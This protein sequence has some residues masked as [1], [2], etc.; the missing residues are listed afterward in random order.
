MLVTILSLVHN[1]TTLLFG[2]YVSAAFLGVRMT[3][4]NVL[5]LLGFSGA[6]GVVYVL[7]F[8]LF[9]EQVTE[10]VYP[11]IV[12]LPLTLFL[13]FYY[14]YKIMLST[15]SVLTAYLC[16]QIS[17]W[18]G[19]AVLDMTHL[20]WAYYSAR[21]V[22]TVT[23]FVLLIRFVSDALAQLAQKSTK[24]ILILGL[25]PFVYYLF[26]YTTGVYTSL[27]YSGL[28][29]VAEFLGFI[30][31][32]AYLLFLFLYFRQY[33]EKCEAEQ[34]NQ[35]M[36]MQQAQSGKEI[37]AIRRSERAVSIL[38]HDMRHFLLSV[39]AFIENGE[40]DKAQAYIREVIDATDATARKKYCQNEIVNMI[41]S[42]HESEMRQRAIDFQYT[43]QLPT[44]LPFSD[45]D[46]TSILSNALE[47]AMTAVAPLPPDQRH[48]RLDMHMNGSKMLL[49]MKNTFAQ[50]PSLRDGLPQTTEAGHGFG[51]QS[52]RYVAEKLNGHCQFSI[53]DEW[54]VLQVIL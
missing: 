53:V 25:M 2:V 30:L 54:F 40:L 26:D 45:V 17:N 46:L 49:S 4:R 43:I 7:C 35:L 1:A 19:V 34:R 21:I 10:Q 36:K 38:R 52:I 3:R 37:E 24:A 22:V 39:S 51:T 42:A 44:Q 6:V 23:A 33:E 47:N 29:V 13:T 11:L 9:G 48:I 32:I 28:E 31:C 12:H 27:L 15:L 8:L 5:T 16:C 41:L 14:K 50:R 20:E 18:V